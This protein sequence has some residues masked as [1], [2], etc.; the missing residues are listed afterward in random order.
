MIAASLRE[1]QSSYL[2]LFVRGKQGYKWNVFK[3]A[4]KSCVFAMVCVHCWEGAHDGTPAIGL[5][6]TCPN[7]SWIWDWLLQIGVVEGRRP[8][9]Q[10]RESF[11][12]WVVGLGA[13]SSQ[14]GT[15][16]SQQLDLNMARWWLYPSL[17]GRNSF[18]SKTGDCAWLFIQRGYLA[19]LF[20]L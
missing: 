5:R 18:A 4:V 17:T 10:G 15:F 1:N 20:V 12:W 9:V 8:W 3:I 6:R 14:V 19:F 13:L 7:E 11:H 16:Q 2:Q